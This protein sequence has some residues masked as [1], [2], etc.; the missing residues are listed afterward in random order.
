[1]LDLLFRASSRVVI[2]DPYFR[3]HQPD[4]TRPLTAFCNLLRGRGATLEIHF[5]DNDQLPGYARFMTDAARALPGVV[6]SGSKVTLHCWKERAGGPRLH[7]RYVLTDVAG[8]QFGD[9]IEQGDVGHQDRVSILEEVSRASLRQQF[10]GT[11][12]AFDRA[13]PPKEFEGRRS[14]R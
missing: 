14:V 8:V 5:A 10:L 6:P 2:V 12:G 9:S 13:G 11:P 3:A 1:M 4:K 7:N